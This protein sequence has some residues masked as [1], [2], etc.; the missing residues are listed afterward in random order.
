M[1]TLATVKTEQN[2][3]IVQNAYAEFAKGNFQGVA[4]ACTDDIVWG[5]YENETVP[6][7][8]S[9]H[10]KKGVVDF[11]TTLTGSVDYT[12]FQPRE[13]FANGDYVFVKGYQA[14]TVKST[15]KT[16]GH[17]FLMEFKLENGKVNS[18]FAYVDTK[19]QAKAF[20]K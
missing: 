9:Y 17:D 10:G 15:G 8:G 20:A 14:A 16:F 6:Y 12:D 3:S 4:D 1:E 2:I 13:F 7:A 19:D 18:F 11:F 5:S